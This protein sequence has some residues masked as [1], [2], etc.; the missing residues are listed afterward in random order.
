MQACND[1]AS[2]CAA[3]AAFAPVVAQLEQAALDCGVEKTVLD[4]C[5]RSM[6]EQ[7]RQL[8]ELAI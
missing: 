3:L 4:Q 1:R 2:L 8:D 7:A 5:L 6:Q